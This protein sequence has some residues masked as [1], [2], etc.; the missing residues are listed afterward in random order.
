MV[1]W[2]KSWEVKTLTPIARS[3][4]NKNKNILLT[5]TTNTGYQELLRS[6]NNIKNVKIL[7]FPYD[8]VPVHRRFIRA[9]R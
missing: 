7:P 4:L 6:F 5:T 3:L 8:I 1:A 2:R 9:L